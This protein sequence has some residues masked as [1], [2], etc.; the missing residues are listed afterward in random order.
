VSFATDYG[1]QTSDDYLLVN[2][3]TAASLINDF[4]SRPPLEVDEANGRVLIDR[5][6]LSSVLLKVRA[7][8]S[9]ACAALRSHCYYG[10]VTPDETRPVAEGEI[11]K[12]L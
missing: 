3:E 8:K 2:I 12:G 5:K 7:T 10:L 6:N 4:H 1:Q 9:G 11:A